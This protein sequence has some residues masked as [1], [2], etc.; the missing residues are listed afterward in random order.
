VAGV[1][2]AHRQVL[3]RI[4]HI[5][6][7]VNNAGMSLLY[8]SVD[9]VGEDFLGK[10]VAVNLKGTASVQRVCG[11]A[12]LARDGAPSADCSR[13]TG[14]SERGLRERQDVQRPHRRARA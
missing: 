3:D 1:R 12:M 4:G 13:R 7:L 14:C 11:Q 6:I 9:A 8:P 10:V 5:D 2:R